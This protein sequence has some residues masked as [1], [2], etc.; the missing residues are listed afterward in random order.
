MSRIETSVACGAVVGAVVGGIAGCVMLGLGVH[1]Q[2]YNAALTALSPWMFG[3][4]GLIGGSLLG[5]LYHSG[6]QI[7]E[8]MRDAPDKTYLQHIFRPTKRYVAIGKPT[9]SKIIFPL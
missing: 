2:W 9:G 4:G 7:K 1:Y 3:L 8:S 5:V 6:M